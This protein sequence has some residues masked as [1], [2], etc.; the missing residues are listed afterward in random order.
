MDIFELIRGEPVWSILIAVYLSAAVLTFLPIIGAYRADPFTTTRLVS[1]VTEEE[2][3]KSPLDK[4]MKDRLLLHYGRIAGSLKMWKKQA[5][6]NKR[7]HQYSLFW[8]TLAAPLVPILTQAIDGNPLS[9]LF[10]TVVS[11]HAAILISFQR[12]LKPDQVYQAY[13]QSESEFYDL[14][15]RMLDRSYTFGKT[16]EEQLETYFTQVEQVRQTARRREISEYF[17]TFDA[18]NYQQQLNRQMNIVTLNTP[19]VRVDPNTPTTTTLTTPIIETP[20]NPALPP[21]GATV[22]INPPAVSSPGVDI[23]TPSLPLHSEES[24]PSGSHD[25]PDNPISAG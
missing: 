23:P 2:I 3:S 10:L 7:L 6:Q 19:I 9:K 8:L 13:R 22:I 17:P 18:E 14:Y 21:A 5:D 24:T 4:G 11:L 25:T 16:P 12:V 20:P 15:R 1:T